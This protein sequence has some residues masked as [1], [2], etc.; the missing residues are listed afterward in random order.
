MNSFIDKIYHKNFIKI[1]WWNEEPNAGDYFGKWLLEKMGY[2]VNYTTKPELIVCGSLLGNAI[3]FY[4]NAKIWGAGFQFESQNLPITEERIFYAVRGKL[5]YKKLQLTKNIALGDPGLLLSKFFQPKTSKEYNVC[6]VTHFTDYK[7]FKEN[8]HRKYYIIN[9]GVN[10]VEKV[11]N[12]I[13]KCYFVFSSSL[14]GIIFSHSLGIPAIHYENLELNSKNN[15]K[16]KDYYSILDITYIKE[17]AREKKLEEI[18]EKYIKNKFLYLPSKKIIKQ[19]QDSLLF[20][21]PY[22]KMENVICAIAKNE[23]K[24]INDWCY[25]HINIGF[26]NIYIYDNNDNST[27]YIGDYIDDDIKDKVHILN[28][29]D[30]KLQQQ[31]S[32]NT[33][34]DLFNHNF[35]WCAY[36]DIDE[37]IIL[38]KW[39][40]ISQFVN[41]KIF[42]DAELIRLKW[43][44]FGDDD[45]I[46]RPFKK[47]IY[48]EIT[49][50]LIGHFYE[51]H[52]K[53]IVKG[54]LNGII[55]NSVHYPHI[56][57][58]VPSQQFL[59]DGSKTPNFTIKITS[60]NE[61]PAYINHYITKTISEFIEQKLYRG[62][63]ALNR[64]LDLNYFWLINKKTK[65]KQDYINIKIN[66]INNK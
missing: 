38:G 6:I 36:I 55:F 40:N 49:N 22:Q 33:F 65:E 4:P 59:S 31:N 26:D 9:M 52:G 58:Q 34:Y 42:K 8:Y 17:K 43:H 27:D 44:I 62:D 11:A 47:P 18:V 46:E 39:D 63:A 10:D 16:F 35:K 24:Y 2:I 19:I 61:E 32:Y 30:K 25:H 28:I 12:E 1:F 23:N 41:D 54:N 20:S 60:K 53:S 14:H 51:N 5:T 21:F 37:F 66:K 56:N 13:N 45:L 48:K 3:T 57:F 15:F 64:Q 29:N 7:W 50:R